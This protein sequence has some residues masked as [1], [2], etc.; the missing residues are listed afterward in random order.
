MKMNNNSEKGELKLMLTDSGGREV[1]VGCDS[2]RLVAMDGTDG[3]GGGSI[4]IRQGHIK[5]VIALE[6][7]DVIAYRSG[8]IVFS[9]NICGG[10]AVVDS[11]T[12]TILSD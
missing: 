4:G 9:E 10:V 6:K 1:S 8:E 11:D 3:R 7:G 5:S 12:V 2:V